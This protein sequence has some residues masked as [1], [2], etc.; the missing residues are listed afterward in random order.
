MTQWERDLGEHLRF[1]VE[2]RN[3]ADGGGP[4][5]RVRTRSDERELLRFDC[6][7]REPHYHFDP[8]GRDEILKLDPLAD[9]IEWTIGELR[10]DAISYLEKAGFSFPSGTGADWSEAEVTQAL[11]AAESAMRNAPADL[12]GL[13]V[14]LLQS[15][16]TEKWNTYPEAELNAWVAEMDY[17]LAD[18][19][20][21]VI[22]TAVDKSDVGYPIAPNAT[23]LREAFAERMAERFDWVI[24]AR[25][26]EILTDVVQGMYVALEAYS[27]PGE[28]VVVQTPI[29]PPFLQSVRE[30]ERTL[31]ENELVVAADATASGSANGYAIDFDRLRETA[32]KRTRVVLFCN[33]HNPTGRVFTQGELETLAELACERDWIVVSDEIHQDLVYEPARHIPFATLGPEVAARTVTLTSATKAFNIPGLRT[34][35]AHFGSADLQKRFNRAFPRHVRGGI[36]TLGL[37]CTNAAWQHSQPWLDEVH[38]YLDANRKFLDAYLSE[39]IPEIV[40]H[41]PDATYL[42]WLDCRAFDLRP[43]P[44][45]FFLKEAAVSLSDGRNFGEQFQGFAR[46]NFATSRN[47][48]TQVLE[49]MKSALPP[50]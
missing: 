15:R 50:R 31:I 6:F 27:R 38:A 10:R 48:L 44:G 42:A 9:I 43:S 22:Q 23:G 30:S 4:T 32:D 11:D 17:P 8:K 34:A 24:D 35:V 5:L 37:Y 20:R 16:I 36:G 25:R 28:G 47:I 19:I 41:S 18:P 14:E 13:Q 29:Y 40:H 39:H 45:A 26:V 46:L 7:A 2:H 12:D 33:P 21:R 3:P 1:S 49:R